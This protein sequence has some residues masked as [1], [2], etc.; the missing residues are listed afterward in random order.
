MK[1]KQYAG[2][3]G[4]R[5]CV[6]LYIALLILGTPFIGNSEIPVAK[7]GSRA[8]LTL[9][10]DKKPLGD[11]LEEIS[12][13]CKIEIIGLEDRAEE[14]VTFSVK[15]ESA[16]KAIKRLFRYIDV[17][18]YAFEYTRTRLRRVSVLPKAKPEISRVV[19]R[20]E[21]PGKPVSDKIKTVK[22]LKVNEG[23]Q[24][25]M[26]DLKRG[27]LIVEYDG[28][29]INS[30]QQLVKAVKSKSPDEIVEMLIFRDRQPNRI[31]LNGGLIGVNILTVT[32]PKMEITQ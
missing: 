4:F 30:A 12:R 21:I 3:P 16:E 2:K 7:T 28:L 25:E 9:S 31:I 5:I 19:P 11:V 22:I 26:L 14:P 18:N 15:E 24:A 8:R 20:M 29:K 6:L 10:A 27:D 13:Q 1:N 23:T 32:V 17:S